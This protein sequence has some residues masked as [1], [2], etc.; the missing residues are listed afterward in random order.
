[1]DGGALGLSLRK[2]LEPSPGCVSDTVTALLGSSFRKQRAGKFCL[3]GVGA[4]GGER[5]GGRC[6]C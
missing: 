5:K 2:E 6:P 4:R 3:G 1:M